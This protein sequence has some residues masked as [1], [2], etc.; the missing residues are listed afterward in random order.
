[1]NY[2][3]LWALPFI[4]AAAVHGA[5]AELYVHEDPQ[6]TISYPN[7]WTQ[8]HTDDML[9][10]FYDDDF[11][12]SSIMVNYTDRMRGSDATVSD[13]IV[14]MERLFCMT[15]SIAQNGWECRE[16]E[17]KSIDAA[18]V[19]GKRAFV[20]VVEYSAWYQGSDG[21]WPIV[22]MSAYVLDSAGTWIIWTETD[23]DMY[24]KHEYDLYS[25]VAS[26][27]AGR[28]SAPVT[29][30]PAP[31]ESAYAVY[32][33]QLPEWSEFDVDSGLRWASEYWED[34]DG[35]VFYR[36]YNPE[37]AD[38]VVGW[39][40]NYGHDQL[41][42]N[43]LRLIDIGLGSDECADNWNPYSQ[44]AVAATLAHE[45]GHGIGY[46][47]AEDSDDLMHATG[48]VSYAS[49]TFEESTMVGYA[50]FHPVC[51]ESSSA[52]YE[53]SFESEPGHEYGLFYVRSVSDFDSFLNGQ[54]HVVG[55]EVS[56]TSKADG[57]CVVGAGGGFVV[58][59][60]G[61]SRDLLAQYQLVLR[62]IGPSGASTVMRTVWAADD[63]RES[64][65]ALETD[66]T[67]YRAVPG[68]GTPVEIRGHMPDI[69]AGEALPVR[70]TVSLDGMAVGHTKTAS[71]SSGAF[72]AV[73]TLPPG[74]DQGTYVVTARTSGVVVGTHSFAVHGQNAA[75]LPPSATPD[76]DDLYQYALDLTNEERTA[77]GLEP[78]ALSSTGSAQDHA[79]DMLQAGYFSHWD[80][81]GVKPYVTYTK[82]G[83][84]GYVA[85]NI[86]GEWLECTAAF[87]AS[88]RLDPLES[89]QDA[90]WGMM[91]DDA[92][93][94]WG[95]RD[96]ILYPYHTHVNIGIAYDDETLYFVQH[97]ENNRI[98][99]NEIRL[100]GKTL[101]MEG[102]IPDGQLSSIGIY[103]DP[104]PRPLSARELNGSE[105]YSS[106]YYEW[107]EF[108]G[109]VQERLWGDWYYDECSDGSMVLEGGLCMPY[110]T[111]AADTWDDGRTRIYA[112][113]SRWL[114]R[115]GL[116]TIV[117]WIEG[118]D[119]SFPSSSVTLEYLDRR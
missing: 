1:M 72:S 24:E 94:N 67:A 60:T 91:Y 21:W 55:C 86:T 27:E 22:A 101:F 84:T 98:Q 39:S 112:D 51:T 90:H 78:V 5:H 96:N 29:A 74:S 89:V 2:G 61:G 119:G 115:D 4:L 44:R 23:K 34:R 80:T 18:T 77:R 15:A 106:G 83:G 59:V 107:G 57:S 71:D 62:E 20:I 13:G 73:F 11:W 68:E 103:E 81:D 118:P 54:R 79:D 3:V 8:E 16:F 117:A 105:P 108:V 33:E 104:D 82:H 63:T 85:E 42:Y 65:G 95:N 109:I 66:R 113:A 92:H 37:H 45:L 36:S 6:F 41:G 100:M 43:Y 31:S 14:A 7:G 48:S 47:H 25:A 110:T 32:F 69:L 19:D 40:K 56:T 26:F 99:W 9:V 30:G 50:A 111:W 10:S 97:F 53:Y 46:D 28:P 116:H 114:E 102:V 87:C 49:E 64:A 52:E 35:T 93:T 17:L 38:F 75:A 76:M 12:T 58:D 88:D 70:L